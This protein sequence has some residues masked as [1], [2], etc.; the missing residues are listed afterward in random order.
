MDGPSLP[1]VIAGRSAL[2]V[3][4]DVERQA[5]ARVAAER[6]AAVREREEAARRAEAIRREGEAALEAEVLAGEAEALREVEDRTRA[7][8]ADAHRALARWTHAQE[9]RLDVLVAAIVERLAGAE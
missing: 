3:F 7:R 1:P 2:P 9:A 4:L 8:V 6:G 5:E